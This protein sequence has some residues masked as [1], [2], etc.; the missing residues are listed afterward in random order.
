MACIANFLVPFPAYSARV[1]RPQNS[2]FFIINLLNWDK[3]NGPQGVQQYINSEQTWLFKE[4]NI[5][6]VFVLYYIWDIS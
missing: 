2:V 3:Q 5:V 6:F 4:Q 1:A